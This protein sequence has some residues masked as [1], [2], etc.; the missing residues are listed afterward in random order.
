MENTFRGFRT[1]GRENNPDMSV[2]EVAAAALK[3]IPKDRA[4]SAEKVFESLDELSEEENELMAEEAARPPSP[5]H[6]RS[7]IQS[8]ADA[9]RTLQL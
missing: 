3:L 6:M 2:K 4:R 5:P 1:V 7:S 8:K 9:I